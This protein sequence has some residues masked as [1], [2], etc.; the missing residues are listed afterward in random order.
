MEIEFV[1][2]ASFI[3]S[4]D[5]VKLLIDPWIEGTAFY[6]GWAL[7]EP[8]KFKYDDFS[9]IT[10]IWFSH[11]HPDHFSPPNLKKIPENIRQ[12]ITILYQ[13]TKDKKV[14]TLCRD[15]KFKQ[16]IELDKDWYSI[17]DQFKVLNVPHT[18]GDSW[19][20]IKAGGRTILNVNDCVFENMAQ[21]EHLKS[22]IGDEKT[23]VLFTQ[24]SYANWAGNKE[25]SE[26]RKKYAKN[27][28]KDIER[29]VSILKPDY[30]IPFASYVWFCHAENFY[31]NDEVNKIDFV[32][33][34]IKTNLKTKPVVLFPGEKWDIESHHDSE[35]SV[36]KWMN[37]YS[38][39]ISSLSVI[40]PKP[41]AKEELIS[42]GNKFIEKIKSGNTGWI[43]IFLR[44]SFIFIEDYNESYELSLQGFKI[45]SVAKEKCDI[46]MSS[47][48]LQYCFRFLWGG[49]TIRVNG[50]YQVPKHGKFFNW[51]LYFQ[52]AQNNN[53]GVKF[54]TRF[55]LGALLK[56]TRKVFS[57]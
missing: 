41:V 43:N 47:D 2:H 8:T 17:T 13:K 57:L 26:T 56:K 23:D 20:C 36:Q 35:A 1:N 30:A 54:D 11:E 40:K 10:H 4:H 34:Y 52:I 21:V 15:L 12:Q 49:S 38:K 18:D 32:Y 27:K 33:D 14:V 42:M 55:V 48:A 29:Q 22:K 7:I 9:T 24:F 6:D 44:P 16:A 53:F 25:D 46:V 5:N 45:A 28:I 3:V 37:S 39:N 50:R 31:M 51:K 19:I